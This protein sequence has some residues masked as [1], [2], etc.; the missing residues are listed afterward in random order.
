IS[1]FGLTCKYER[2]IERRDAARA[3]PTQKSTLLCELDGNMTFPGKAFDDRHIAIKQARK[4][5]E[6]T[7]GLLRE[8][9]QHTSKLESYKR[10]IKQY[11]DAESPPEPYRKAFVQ[12]QKRVEAGLR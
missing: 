8:P 11:T 9:E 1:P 10:K 6:E 4:F 7:D 12:V 5:F 2:I 3:M